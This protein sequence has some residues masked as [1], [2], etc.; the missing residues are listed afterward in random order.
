MLDHVQHD[1][2]RRA[3]L[4]DLR[5]LVAVLRVFD[6]ELVQTELV[7]QR[8]QLG[9]VRILER[10]PDEAVRP[11]QVRSDLADAGCRRLSAVLIGDAVDQHRGALASA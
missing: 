8:S 6:G 1:E 10:D 11:A 9:G 4:L 2:E 5:P 3:V 7:L